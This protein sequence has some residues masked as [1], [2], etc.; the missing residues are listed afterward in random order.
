M[1]LEQNTNQTIG[2]R[3]LFIVLLPLQ[4]P[5]VFFFS[6]S[7]AFIP[8]A[9]YSR[10][11]S[12]HTSKISSRKSQKQLKAG[13]NFNFTPFAAAQSGCVCVFPSTNNTLDELFQTD[14]TKATVFP[15][16]SLILTPNTHIHIAK[17]SFTI[18]QRPDHV[19][20]HDDVRTWAR[21]FDFRFEITINK[22]SM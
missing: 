17:G 19:K 5:K 8:S 9:A 18:S 21:C 20:L 12:L 16:S 10:L 13:L 14:A 2:S 4:K 7:R 22:L 3:L 1:C 15:P 11:V 6:F